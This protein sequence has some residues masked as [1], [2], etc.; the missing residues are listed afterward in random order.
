MGTHKL[1]I[2]ICVG[3]FYLIGKIGIEDIVIEQGNKEFNISLKIH[4]EDIKK[5]E[6]PEFANSTAE[7]KSNVL[8]IDFCTGEKKWI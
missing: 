2:S 5:I 4:D 6:D 7:A 1:P 8:Q 3:D